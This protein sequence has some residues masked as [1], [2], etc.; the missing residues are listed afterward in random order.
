[1]STTTKFQPHDAQFAERVRESFDRQ[2]I[3]K[4][5]G[6]RLSDVGP[7]MTVIELPYQKEITQQHGFVHAGALATILDSACGYAAYTLMPRDAAVL[8][9]EY[10]INMLSPATGDLIRATA[11]VFRA[12]RTVSVVRGS[13]YSIKGTEQ[14]HVAEMTATMMTIQDR[15]GLRG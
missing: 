6:A 4:T 7:G 8:S 14:K 5:L 10:K 3:M 11:E 12:G 9:I 15:E 1:M 2:E 13:A